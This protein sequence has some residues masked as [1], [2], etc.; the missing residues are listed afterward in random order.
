MAAACSDTAEVSN[1]SADTMYP[2]I[3]T[4]IVFPLL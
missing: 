2:K 3:L 4:L 1:G